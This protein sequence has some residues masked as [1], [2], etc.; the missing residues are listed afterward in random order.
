[1]TRQIAVIQIR[2]YADIDRGASLLALPFSDQEVYQEKEDENTTA[3][4]DG[5]YN[6]VLREDISKE[7]EASV[8]GAL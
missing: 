3:V 5:E 7:V 6:P 4:Q 2:V 8:E 1:M